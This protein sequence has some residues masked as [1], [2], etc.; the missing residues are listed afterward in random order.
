MC[1]LINTLIL[2]NNYIDSLDYRL[3]QLTNNSD[4]VINIQS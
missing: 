3:Y 2:I 4:D 1:L